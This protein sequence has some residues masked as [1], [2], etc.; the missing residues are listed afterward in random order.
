M[1]AVIE[2]IHNEF[3]TCA[4]KTLKSSKKFLTTY[5]PVEAKSSADVDFLKSV[6]FGGVDFVREQ[7]EF[8]ANAVEKNFQDN[9]KLENEKALSERIMELKKS[10]P[11]YSVVT[12]D[13]VKAICN[14]YGLVFASSKFYIGS[15]P[16]KNIAD[17]QK[18]IKDVIIDDNNKLYYY[19]GTDETYWLDK[20][21]DTHKIN[22]FL[23]KHLSINVTRYHSD[24]RKD[25][26]LSANIPVYCNHEGYMNG[27]KAEDIRKKN[28]YSDHRYNEDNTDDYK[29]YVNYRNYSD[30]K[31]L[32]NF[33]ITAPPKDFDF[34]GYNDYYKSQ[35]I[36]KIVYA[37]N[38]NILS[39]A[40]NVSG[41]KDIYLNV[42]DPVILKHVMGYQHK[43]AKSSKDNVITE[44][45][46]LF[47]LVTLWGIEKYDPLLN[48]TDPIHY[49]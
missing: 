9:L 23:S 26:L 18:F 28:H 38:D 49:N 25:V 29:F 48:N 44:I 34:S 42:D 13:T 45:K 1:E 24:D 11:N 37:K 12:E 30:A 40:K 16:N 43:S 3:K 36:N 8:N 22:D 15:I 39:A 6:G 31:E 47:L 21:F 7:D 14:K 41:V 33:F 20:K 32:D 5:K 27:K 2:K 17:L 19:L 46:P 4:V 35:G 10:F